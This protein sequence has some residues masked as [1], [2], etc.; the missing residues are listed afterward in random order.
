M[1]SLEKKNFANQLQARSEAS[2]LSEKKQRNETTNLKENII[3]G[4]IVAS[5]KDKIAWK[6]N[7]R[8]RTRK[9]IIISSRSQKKLR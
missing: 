7:L 4:I 9:I 6:I 5:F 1:S 3:S 2:K 8:K